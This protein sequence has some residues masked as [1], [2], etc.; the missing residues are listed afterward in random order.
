MYVAI[1]L[2]YIYDKNNQFC[3][4]HAYFVCLMLAFWHFLIFLL[5]GNGCFCVFSTLS[6]TLCFF[7]FLRFFEWKNSRF[8]CFL[9]SQKINFQKNIEISAKNKASGL[10]SH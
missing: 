2:P 1:I 9:I 8:P 4:P 6:I 5:F 10:I 7:V 3:L